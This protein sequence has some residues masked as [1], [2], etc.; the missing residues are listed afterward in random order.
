MSF[1]FL[2]LETP[3]VMTTLIRFLPICGTWLFPRTL[4]LLTFLM[5]RLDSVTLCLASHGMDLQSF[6]MENSG[7]FPQ[8]QELVTPASLWMAL[9]QDSLLMLE[10]Q[11]HMPIMMPRLSSWESQFMPPL[12][13]MCQIFRSILMLQWTWSPLM[14]SSFRSFT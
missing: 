6:I 9:L 13:Q 4:T 12:T 14:D 8:L 2:N 1:R 11:E 7:D 3:S 5:L 10:L